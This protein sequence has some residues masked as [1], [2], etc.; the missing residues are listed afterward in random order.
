MTTEYT[1]K[2][3]FTKIDMHQSIKSSHRALRL[4]SE[5]AHT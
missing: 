1:N 3:F 2:E 4:F 5:N